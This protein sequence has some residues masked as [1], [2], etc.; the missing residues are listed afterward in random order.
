M[1]SAQDGTSLTVTIT[2][3]GRVDTWSLTCDPDAGDHPSPR[4]ACM[5]LDTAK[6]WGQNPFDPTP[7]DNVC[8][9]VFG[10]EETATVTGVW[11]G[12]PVDASFDRTNACEISRWS[13]AIPLLVVQGS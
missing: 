9:E 13:N 10:G 7:S 6:Q 1:P 8:A 11:D 2:N 4:A 5:F 3:R 12:K